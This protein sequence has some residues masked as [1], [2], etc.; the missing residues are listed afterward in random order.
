MYLRKFIGC[1]VGFYNLEH[2]FFFSR[3][4]FPGDFWHAVG[5][6][7]RDR[8]ELLD[9]RPQAGEVLVH[10]A[11]EA[12]GDVA[13]EVGILP[14]QVAEREVG[15]VKNVHEL[16][17]ILDA[18]AQRGGVPLELHRGKIIGLDCRVHRVG[19]HHAALER[20]HE[21]GRENGIE[22][23]EGIAEQQQAFAA[24]MP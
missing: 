1:F 22:K 11:G 4:R 20:E 12:V 21:A 19:R 6:F 14:D 9:G 2:P 18:F 17:H 10:V 16:A 7:V 23:A 13:G 24:A 8:R 3:H 5:E 15:M